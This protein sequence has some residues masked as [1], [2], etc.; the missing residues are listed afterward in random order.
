MNKTIAT[1]REKTMVELGWINGAYHEADADKICQ[2]LKFADRA[3]E[4]QVRKYT[5]EPYIYHPIAVANLVASVTSDIDM[6][7]AALL[8]DTVEDCDVTLSQIR[9]AFGADV[10]RHVYWLTD[11][12]RPTDG[13]RA[14]RKALDR[15]HTG[16][17][18]PDSKTIKLADL[19]DNS[20]SIVARDKGFAKVYMAEK[21]ELLKVL[22][23]GNA[24]LFLR[25]IDIVAR[26]EFN[27]GKLAQ[28]G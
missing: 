17:A 16:R 22:T 28:P 15:K 18:P 27:Q 11:A 19:I 5:G 10:E 9:D 12:S 1:D 6:I 25:A 7:C 4:G 13:N 3:H 8:H 26:Y 14:A 21:R 23:E 2:V 24:T 20:K